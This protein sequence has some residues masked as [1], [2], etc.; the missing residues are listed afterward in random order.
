[1]LAAMKPLGVW[2]IGGLAVIDSAAIPVPIDALLI[3]YVANDH[4][5]F[6]IYCFMA[7]LGSAVGS[8]VPYYLGRAGGELFLL[9]RINRQ[10]YEQL[11]DRFEKQEFLAIMVPAMMPPPMPVKL[12]EFAAGVFEMK[13]LWFFSAIFVGKF[14]RFLIWAII[15]I[16]YGPTILH[17]ITSAFHRHLGYV[18]GIGGIVGVVLLVYVLRKV[19]DRRRG[20]T[21]PVEEN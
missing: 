6:L 2:G 15:T 8:L 3:D 9:K 7:A 19:F 10:R 16:T 12:F 4:T 1:M 5:K 13:S 17:S 18:M 14:V 11:R 21:L 20:T